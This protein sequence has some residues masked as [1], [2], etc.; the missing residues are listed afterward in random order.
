MGLRRELKRANDRVNELKTVLN[1]ASRDI[2]LYNE[3]ICGVATGKVKSICPYCEDYMECIRKERD[4]A[5]CDEWWLA[6]DLSRN[7][8]QEVQEEE[9]QEEKHE[10]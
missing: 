6:Y 2:K 8:T 9:K 5:G 1:M 3:I 7:G 10:S 4:K